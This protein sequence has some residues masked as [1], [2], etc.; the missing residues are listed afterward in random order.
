MGRPRIVGVDYGS[1]RVGLAMSDPMK[2][3]AQP[4]GTFSPTAAIETLEQIQTHDGIDLIVLGWPIELDGTEGS[5]VE[6]VRKFEKRLKKRLAGVSVVRW[7][8]RMTSKEAQRTILASGARK[9]KRRQK[10]NVDAVAAAIIL[11]GYLDE[12]EQ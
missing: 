4:V 5:A 11:Q 3:F 2:M 8:E 6:A 9:K 12:E 10:G 1:V 7:D